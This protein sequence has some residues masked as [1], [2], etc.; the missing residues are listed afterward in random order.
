M[1]GSQPKRWRQIQRVTESIIL[2]DWGREQTK[3]IYKTG[4]YRLA[5]VDII[6][7]KCL[8]NPQFP[9]CNNWCADTCNHEK[10]KKEVKGN[11]FIIS[12]LLFFTCPEML[13]PFC[14]PTTKFLNVCLLATTND[15]ASILLGHV[16]LLT[17]ISTHL[18]QK[19]AGHFMLYNGHKYT[20]GWVS[21]C[22]VG[23]SAA[24]SSCET[25]SASP[26]RAQSLELYVA[27]WMC[28]IPPS[29]QRCWQSVLCP[30]TSN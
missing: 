5:D 6:I 24:P 11:K 29:C 3:Q 30:D 27:P 12:L 7:I 28:N 26:P 2:G 17:S 8:H 22:L 13:D 21:P 4:I 14:L 9:T 16:I 23:G 15:L 20:Q 18:G 10:N 25:C 1:V 19:A